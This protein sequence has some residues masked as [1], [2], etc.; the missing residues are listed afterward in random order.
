MLPK[1]K[2]LILAALGLLNS[3][4]LAMQEY[5]SGLQGIVYNKYFVIANIVLFSLI[6][7]LRGIG[8]RTGHY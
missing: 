7:W 1:L 6:F 5:I 4:A 2:T 3:V 8:P